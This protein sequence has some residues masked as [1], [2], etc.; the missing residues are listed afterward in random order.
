MGIHPDNPFGIQP[1]NRLQSLF[2]DGPN[3]G[4]GKVT[5]GGSQWA[6]VFVS[7]RGRQTREN[8]A[9]DLHRLGNGKALSAWRKASKEINC[10]FTLTI[11]DG[12][13]PQ[14]ATSTE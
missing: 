5:S 10:R 14:S 8:L 11:A 13:S 7:G 9:A 4:H 12:I 6:A 2:S 3:Q 1:W